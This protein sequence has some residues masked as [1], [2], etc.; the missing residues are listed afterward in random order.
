M[1]LPVRTRALG[2]V[3]SV[4]TAVLPSVLLLPAAHAESG[5]SQCTG[6]DGVV[7]R[8]V[9]V[10]SSTFKSTHADVLDLGRGIGYHR[11]R[12][13]TR[14]LTLSAGVTNSVEASGGVGWKIAKLDAKV[15]GTLALSGQHT[16]T[17]SVTEDFDI[18]AAD[19]NRKILFYHGTQY[20]RGAWHQLTCSRVPGHG[21]EYSGAVRSFAPTPRHGAIP[22]NH[23]LYS[24]GTVRYQVT[25]QAGC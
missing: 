19:H 17:S 10:T 24:P 22:C 16:T 9:R 1:Q 3:L 15:S 7:S 18:N 25:V 14:V 13:L 5:Y 20:V 6:Q 2:A 23:R 4:A 21:T 12:T 11:S 8:S